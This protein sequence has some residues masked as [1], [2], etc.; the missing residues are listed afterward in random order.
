MDPKLSDPS[1]EKKDLIGRS[2]PNLGPKKPILYNFVY[3]LQISM[4]IVSPLK[5]L[6]TVLILI[7]AMINE[8]ALNMS[9]A[10]SNWRY[11]I[12][13]LVVIGSEKSSNR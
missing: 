13:F 11:V 5:L 8:T 12:H 2:I 3:Y 1:P 9:H 7:V 4:K 6:L 10:C